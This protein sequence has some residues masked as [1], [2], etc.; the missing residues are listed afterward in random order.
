MSTGQLITAYSDTNKIPLSSRS[1]EDRTTLYDGTSIDAYKRT[2]TES[3]LKY[4]GM[5]EAAAKTCQVA[6]NDPSNGV[7][8]TA[9]RNGNNGSWMTGVTTKTYTDWTVVA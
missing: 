4:V 3:T 6:L 1:Y 7:N 9:K 2:I 8:A 5:T